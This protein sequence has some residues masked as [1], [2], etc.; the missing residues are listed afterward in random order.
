MITVEA[1]D[2]DEMIENIDID[3]AIEEAADKGT[4]NIDVEY[5]KCKPYTYKGSDDCEWITYGE[6]TINITDDLDID[7]CEL[8]SYIKELKCKD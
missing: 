7:V 1:R 3:E 6:V 2:Y 5:G 8:L 4:P